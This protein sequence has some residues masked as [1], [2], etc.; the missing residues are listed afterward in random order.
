MPQKDLELTTGRRSA[1]VGLRYD[2][3]AVARISPDIKLPQES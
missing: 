2:R 1:E 3:L